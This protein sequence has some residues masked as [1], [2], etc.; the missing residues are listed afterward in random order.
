MTK[1][2]LLESIR[3]R[4]F[5]PALCVGLLA[6]CE[7]KQEVSPAAVDQ[8]AA[9]PPAR[10]ADVNAVRVRNAD[11]E[12]GNW[13]AHGR[14]YSEQRYS[15]LDSINT[16]TVGR[17]G[18]AWSYDTGTLRGMEAT[19]IVVDGVMF[20]TGSWSKVFALDARSG[21]E[22]W[23]YDPQVPGKYGVVACCDVVNRGVAVWE[24]SVFS[25]SL[26]G[27]LF[28]L[29]AKTG[30]RQWEVKTTPD[31]TAY[32]ITGAP[33]V[34]DGLVIIGNGGA[35]YGVRGYIS[36][37]D[38]QSGELVWRFYTVPG[39]PDLPVENPALKRAMETWS[40]GG[41]GHKWWEIGGGGTAWDAMAYDPELDLLYVGTGNGSPWNRW[42]RSPGGGDNLYLSSILAIK[43]KTA[44][45]VWYYQT[46]P[47]D[48]W[49]Y[50]A[51]QHL[52]LADLEIEGESRKVIMQAPKNGFFYVLD[53][54]TG[55]FLSADPYA[56]VNW[57]TGVDPLTGRPV[58]NPAVSYKDS[59]Q[60][61]LPG[62]GGAHNW[63]PMAFNPGT[64]LVYIPVHDAEFVYTNDASYEYKNIGWNTGNDFDLVANLLIEA[65]VDPEK[66]SSVG[67]LKAFD[68]VTRKIAWQRKLNTAVNGGVL[69][70]A[71][72]LVF[73]G[74]GDGYFRAY[75]ALTGEPRWSAEVRTGII[76]PPI[77]YELDGEQYVAVLAGYGGGGVAT[78]YDP[79][80]V[81]HEYGNDGRVI[82][83]K[84]NTGRDTPRPQD[85]RGPLPEPPTIEADVETLLA[86]AKAYNRYC[87]VCHGFSAIGPY[88]SPPDLRYSDAAVYE[89]YEEILLD[90]L[91]AGNGMVSFAEVLDKDDVQNLR[92]YVASEAR[93][94]YEKQQSP[95]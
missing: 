61:V 10:L 76:A 90:G 9:P 29:D 23:T 24:G 32:T 80:A 2:N 64:G 36:A 95:E 59:A 53:R 21:K 43:P 49:D 26:D 74:T 63:H 82:T 72:G 3:W 14:T 7:A 68:P 15:P 39:D 89:L 65:E 19:P 1:I 22:L 58:E 45:L 35:E 12:P 94:G 78:N 37:Y 48:N 62:P 13:L 84:L 42:V 93:R 66:P 6:A 87:A 27:R 50:T 71:G 20:A 60:V 17:L 11:A 47:G 46:T 55:E 8:R 51:T 25:A 70:T 52:I 41:T 77:S 28:A 34:I 54:V 38:A 92:A 67:Y 57:A 16:E 5:A 88:S 81:H 31:D 30:V 4:F 56:K 73:Q 79:R 91:L 44:E 86:G 40:T 33:R 69:T 18:F 83:F 85:K 75:D